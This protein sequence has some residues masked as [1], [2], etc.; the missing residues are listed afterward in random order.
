MYKYILYMFELKTNGKYSQWY[1]SNSKAFISD[2]KLKDR[3]YWKKNKC[4]TLE[5]QLNEI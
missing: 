4:F 2:K 1:L 5:L 3:T